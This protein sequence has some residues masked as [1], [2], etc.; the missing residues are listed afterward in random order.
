MQAAGEGRD[1]A[2][3]E[4]DL[5]EQV[6]AALGEGD[7]EQNRPTIFRRGQGCEAGALGQFFGGR[8]LRPL[9]PSYSA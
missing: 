8:R 2:E 3:A 6:R 5:V 7:A 4:Q 9:S 1:A